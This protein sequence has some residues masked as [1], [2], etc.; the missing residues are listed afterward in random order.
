MALEL[1]DLD[2][3]I[4]QQSDNIVPASNDCLLR[5]YIAKLKPCTIYNLFIGFLEQGKLSNCAK[6]IAHCP[7]SLSHG[8][9]MRRVI[10]PSTPIS[11]NEL[12]RLI[13]YDTTKLDE[14]VSFLS[15]SLVPFISD[16]LSRQTQSSLREDILAACAYYHSQVIL[17]MNESNADPFSCKQL[18]S[19]CLD[20]L[21]NI[22]SFNHD[23]ESTQSSV[24]HSLTRFKQLE[25]DLS[26]IIEL[27][28]YWKDRVTLTEVQEL[29]FKGLLYDRLSSVDENDLKRDIIET[30]KPSIHRYLSQTV[31]QKDRDM[32]H[33][34]VDGI[35][36]SWIDY[37][38]ANC[39]V[40]SDGADSNPL[41][42]PDTTSNEMDESTDSRK[43]EYCSLSR[44]VMVVLAIQDARYQ[45]MAIIKTM[46]LSSV[47]QGHDMNYDLIKP[48]LDIVDN[49][50]TQN[51]ITSGDNLTTVDKKT[52]DSLN[53]I[54]RLYRIRRITSQY[55]I[56][57]LDPCDSKQ[58]RFAVNYIVTRPF[59]STKETS[60]DL[61][62][63]VIDCQSIK[64][65]LEIISAWNIRGISSNSVISRG[66]V[67]RIIAYCSVYPHD[68]DNVN[69]DVNVS[70]N[71]FMNV[72]KESL[73][74]VH[75]SNL[76]AVIDD[77]TKSLLGVFD[78]IFHELDKSYIILADSHK[79]PSDNPY[80][81]HI[82]ESMDGNQIKVQAY[83]IVRSLIHILV[84]YLD[85][86]RSHTQNI[87]NNSYSDISKQLNDLRN[88]R[89]L[90]ELDIYMTLS[91]F[92]TPKVMKDLTNDLAERKTNRILSEYSQSDGSTLSVFDID[93]MV[94]KI[95]TVTQ[96]SLS[97]Y[98]SSVVNSLLKKGRQV[99]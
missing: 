11:L 43:Y 2:E 38:T 67:S 94:T 23:R 81:S 34:S 44:I 49:I 56:M 63:Q 48:I 25:N 31:S 15:D 29:G 57:N 41:T 36:Y 72:L 76:F 4:N 99:R 58:I 35:V 26:I 65:A 60:T 54:I 83:V 52:S 6:L 7:S 47:Y 69:Q 53:E 18:V 17:L 71:S 39:I 75:E 77:I 46:Q 90:Q 20:L 68:R 59:L 97:Q 22:D 50:V 33:D 80:P 70:E 61:P 85:A 13:S 9:V 16:C 87:S 84:Y 96:L 24:D 51:D 5:L 66:V 86:Y 74:L 78:D 8:A 32:F 98:V 79:N 30:M 28:I 1:S 21:Q 91:S 45:A 92:N 14:I 95:C 88:L 40:R 3:T 64:D 73:Q 19:Y 27:M 93:N 10:S 12:I 89:I 42:S 62:K 82:V 55:G 37:V